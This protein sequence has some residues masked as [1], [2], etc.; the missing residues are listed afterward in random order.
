MIPTPERAVSPESGLSGYIQSTRNFPLLAMDDEQTLAIAWHEHN[1]QGAA[2]KLVTSHLRLVVKIARGYRGYGLPLDDLVSEGNVG[3]MKAINHFDPY[4]GFRLSTYAMWWIRSAIQ[5][6]VLRSWSLVK[7]GTTAAQKK[8]FFNLR[9]T[10]AQLQAFEEE[11][12]TPEQV[13]A[14]AERLNV[15]EN[16]VVNMNGRMTGGDMSLNAPVTYE[17]ASEWLDRLPEEKESHDIIFAERQELENS[18]RLLARAMKGLAPRENYILTERRL[19]DEPTTLDDLSKHFGVS[20]ERIRQIEIRAY[21]RIKKSV[22]NMAY[23]QNSRAKD[24]MRQ[25]DYMNG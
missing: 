14:I 7:M 25:F 8:L 3:M 15:S 1:D 4:K 9:K 13:T 12:L 22:R 19:K 6:Y 11:N 10:K 23:H 18:C 2:E 17:G 21:E 16:E 24:K 20:R 5:E